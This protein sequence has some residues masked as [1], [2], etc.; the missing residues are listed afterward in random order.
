MSEVIYAIPTFLKLD[1]DIKDTAVSYS[2]YNRF[3][4]PYE[5]W[6]SELSDTE[7]T[8]DEMSNAVDYVVSPY[9]SK[10]QPEMLGV[11]ARIKNMLFYKILY[12]VNENLP[13]ADSGKYTSLLD[14]I[15]D[16]LEDVYTFLTVDITFAEIILL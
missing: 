1:S 2:L 14:S 16:D 11:L 6:T 13:E 8:L 15:Q 3:Y 12:Q 10:V 7:P 9:V 5:S 4:K